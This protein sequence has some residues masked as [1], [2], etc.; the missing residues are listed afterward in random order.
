MNA[1]VTPHKLIKG[2]T[3][4]WEV[5]IGMEIHAQ[6]TSNSKLFSGAATEFGGEPNT[7]SRWWTPRCRA[8]CP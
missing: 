5:V 2:Q 8:C 3:G 1:T 7:M 4:D 6:V